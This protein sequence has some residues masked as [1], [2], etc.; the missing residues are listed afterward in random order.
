[1][2]NKELLLLIVILV[3][4]LSTEEVQTIDC[5]APKDPGFCYG[6]FLKYYYDPKT[7]LCHSFVYGGCR[8]NG[9]RFD[10]EEKC[11][12]ACAGTRFT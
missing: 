6:Y 12:A 5:T 11:M 9:N 1:M 2:G 8:G 3:S 7:G 4:C 10:S